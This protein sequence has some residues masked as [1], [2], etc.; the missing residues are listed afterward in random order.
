MPTT[1]RWFPL[2]LLLVVILPFAASDTRSTA[3]PHLWVRPHRQHSLFIMD[4]IGDDIWAARATP[5]I[6]ATRSTP[7]VPPRLPCDAPTIGLTATDI[8]HGKKHHVDLLLLSS[9]IWIQLQKKLKT[10]Y[11]SIEPVEYLRKELHIYIIIR[12]LHRELCSYF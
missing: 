3:C 11:I 10:A 2:L 12:D 4:R 1:S 5:H 8:A 9:K 7:R 6:V